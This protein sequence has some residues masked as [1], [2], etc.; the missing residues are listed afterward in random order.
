MSSKNI[1]VIGV[2]RLGLCLALLIEKAGYNVLGVD[3]FPNYVEQLNQKKYKTNEPELEELL[4][5]SKNFKA[6]LDL[7]EGLDHSDI[8]FIVVQTP[9]GG[10]DRFYD[11]TILSNLLVKINKYQPM[12]KEIIIGCTIMPKY[13]EEIGKLLI[14]DCKNCLLSYNPEFIAQGE[15]IKGFRNPD[16]ILIGTDSPNVGEKLKEIYNQFIISSPKYCIMKP[17]DAE[18][19]K[20]SINGFVTTKLSFA[21]MISDMCDTLGADKNVILNS[22]GSD[23]RIGN[24]YFRPGYSFGG[25]CFPRDTK[26]LKLLIDKASINS[27]LLTATTKYNE[28]HV[29]F[30]VEQMLHDNKTEYIIEDICYKENSKIP[31]IEESAKLKIAF[32]LV[33]KGKKVIIKDEEGLIAEAKKEYG[34]LFEY[35]IV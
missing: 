22:V 17:L 11:H 29:K 9:N 30:Q 6:T 14:Q 24:K 16:I 34:N 8:I 13:I 26:A 27:D 20:I 23:S 7:K 4:Q 32:E 12:N 15:I 2:G 19:V 21:N 35:I 5:N 31:I 1:T 10:G 25:P 18:I 3:I 28:E 33:K